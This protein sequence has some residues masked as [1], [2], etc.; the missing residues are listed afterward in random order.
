MFKNN[1]NH[2]PSFCFRLFQ[3][4][5]VSRHDCV[6]RYS[7][8]GFPASGLPRFLPKARMLFLG[9]HVRRQSSFGS[10]HS[11]SLAFTFYFI[12]IL[13][14]LLLGLIFYFIYLR[15]TMNSMGGVD[16]PPP[17]R[18]ATWLAEGK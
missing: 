17:S 16:P 11:R 13:Y 8:K 9:C 2:F 14:L 12:I 6:P 18:P 1:W 7:L 10:I 5:A 3:L 4:I 15:P